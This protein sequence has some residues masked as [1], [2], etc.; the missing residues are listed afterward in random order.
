MRTIGLAIAGLL[1]TT[2]YVQAQD[3]D[4]GRGVFRRCQACHKVG[5]AALTQRAV[6]PHLNGL[7]GRKAGS[8]EGFNYSKANR[9]SGITW[10]EE[11]FT[12]YIKNPRN[13]MKGTRMAFA[14]IRDEREIK[15]LIAY[16]KQFQADGTLAK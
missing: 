15:D 9:E 2:A 5:E 10:S 3:P 12:D 1:A 13:Y 7:F 11:N 8:V 6:G 4:A 16:L 14:G